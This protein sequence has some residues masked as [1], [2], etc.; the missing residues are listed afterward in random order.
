[1]PAF[2]HEPL[3]PRTH[4]HTTLISSRAELH[5]SRWNAHAVLGSVQLAPHVR[6]LR[7]RS[8]GAI[9]AHTIIIEG[10][11]AWIALERSRGT[12]VCAARAACALAAAEKSRCPLTKAN[13]A[14]DYI[15]AE[16]MASKGDVWVLPPA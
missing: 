11:A 15:F 8:R 3:P 16:L 6:S 12:R 4:A 2:E 7:L 5:G 9:P 13:P 1:M 14:R 10:R